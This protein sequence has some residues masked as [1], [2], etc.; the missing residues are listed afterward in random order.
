ME[1]ISHSQGFAVT[2]PCPFEV[3]H[4][5]A[6]RRDTGNLTRP[7]VP[8]S[9]GF[10]G[11]HPAFQDLAGGCHRQKLAIVL[12]FCSK[13]LW[14]LIYVLNSSRRRSCFSIPEPTSTHR[15][16]DFWGLNIITWKMETHLRIP[17]LRICGWGWLDHTGSK[18]WR[19]VKISVLYLPYL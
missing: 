5:E 8:W 17:D 7:M 9:V 10:C 4:K 2:K 6:F 18:N 14:I 15:L 12:A 3:R 16:T 13:L 19:M 1:H 11:L